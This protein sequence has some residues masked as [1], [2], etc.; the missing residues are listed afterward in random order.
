MIL[1]QIKSGRGRKVLWM[2]WIMDESTRWRT[3][4][5]RRV[6]LHPTRALRLLALVTRGLPGCSGPCWWIAASSISPAP[7]ATPANS[8]EA[9]EALSIVPASAS[10]PIPIVQQAM[11]CI[12]PK[13]RR[14]PR[15]P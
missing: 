5:R 3:R 4:A 13:L 1:T 15:S 6:F 11:P 10:P 7:P 12:C 2:Q 8:H 9:V 14:V